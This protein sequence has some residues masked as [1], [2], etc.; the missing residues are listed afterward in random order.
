M[1]LA[2]EKFL[3]KQKLALYA[4]ASVDGCLLW[5]G[6]INRGGYGRLLW[7]G[8]YQTAHRL[9]YE[10]AFGEVPYWMNVLHRCASPSCVNP[11]HLLLGTNADKAAKAR[12]AK[13]QLNGASKLTAIQ[14]LAIRAAE[15]SQREIAARYSVS[16]Q[17][18]GLILRR[19]IWTHI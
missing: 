5:S 2:A 4:E 1:S 10:V 18:V 15:G 11:S 12:L 13:G 6:V 14:V 8:R 19:Q 7:Q 3:L 16:H 9:A 17:N